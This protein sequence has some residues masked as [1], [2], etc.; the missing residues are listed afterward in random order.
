LWGNSHAKAIA[1][2]AL[3]TMVFSLLVFLIGARTFV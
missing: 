3:A 1:G 2:Q